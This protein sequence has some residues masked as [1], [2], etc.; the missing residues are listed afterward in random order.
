M[1]HFRHLARRGDENNLGFMAYI[2][3]IVAMFAIS[4]FVFRKYNMGLA[5]NSRGQQFRR[6]LI[7][8]IL[9]FAVVACAGRCME[10]MPVVMAALTSLLWICTYNVL[11]DKTYR[12]C[13]PD[14]DNHIDIAF[15]IYL[16]GWLVGLGS[17]I[18]WF[19]PIVS[20]I[21]MGGIESLLILVVI[22]QIGYYTIYRTCIDNAGMQVLLETNGNEAIEFATSFNLAKLMA[23]IA[24]IV[25]TITICFALNIMGEASHMPSLPF[26]VLTFGL[27]IFF[28]FYIWKVHHGLFVRTGIM[29]LYGDISEYREANK[30]Y[31]QQVGERLGKLE[32][33]LN[34]PPSSRP[35]TIIMVIGE[36]ACRDYMSAF[37]EQPWETTPWQ[38]KM[39]KNDKHF[40]FFDNAY[41]CAMQTVPS[42]EKAL[43]EKNL[44]NNKEFS[45][46][47]SIVDIA[48]KA[49]YRVHWYSNQG[50]IGSSETPVTLVA[51]TADV[52]KWTKQEVGRPYYDSSL[53]DFLDEINPNVN[54]F[55]VLHLKGSHFNYENRYPPEYAKENGLTNG[56]DVH[57]YRNSIHYTD[58]ILKSFYEYASQRLNL[59]AMVYYSDHGAIPDKRRM[60]WFLGFGMVR[61]PMWVYLSDR[62]Q[63]QHPN[64]ASALKANKD[65]YFTN[66]L[67]YELMCGIFDVSSEHYDEKSSL[68]SSKYKYTLNML[69]TDDGRVKVADDEKIG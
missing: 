26:I 9:S 18:G 19:S 32:V 28:S 51:E 3:G 2:I 57:N 8:S 66:D 40:M 65:K 50:H 62:Y 52:A 22:F 55:V 46:S 63:S 12:K 43:T 14:Y 68:A 20:A 30:K 23:M 45:S 48:H 15:G 33:K 27:T 39:R 5:R 17:I 54:N 49:G 37:A 13:S 47:C 34:V 24:P 10:E 67:A 64:I 25:L 58:Y 61:I 56:D 41:S 36:S 6:Y 44:Y 21:V 7:G 11:Y 31:K 38:G 29:T 42:L 59:M 69:L 1:L 4:Y 60:P 53:I 35:H 16:F